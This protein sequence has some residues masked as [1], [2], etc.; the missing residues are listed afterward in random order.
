MFN[1]QR[2]GLLLV[3]SI[4]YA[5]LLVA[6]MF[7]AANKCGPSWYSKNTPETR[8]FYVCLVA[9]VITASLYQGLGSNSPERAKPLEEFYP[10]KRRWHTILFGVFAITL[11]GVLSYVFAVVFWA[12][13]TAGLPI[14]DLVSHVGDHLFIWIS[15]GSFA[16]WQDI[17]LREE[18]AEYLRQKTVS[19]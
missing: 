4:C 15:F 9:Q 1:E 18:E 14:L 12:T 10:S 2:R 16:R 6:F 19:A 7:F 8:F 3:V 13:V 17:E 11:A 5:L